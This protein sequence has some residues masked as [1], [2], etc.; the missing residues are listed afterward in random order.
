ME[1]I[2]RPW[3]VCVTADESGAFGFLRRQI[4]TSGVELYWDTFSSACRLRGLSSPDGLVF[5]VPLRLGPRSRYWQRPVGKD[6]LPAMHP[7]GLDWV[8]DRRQSHLMLVIRSSLLRR[9]FGE[10]DCATLEGSVRKHCVPAKAGEF[11]RLGEWLSG[12][13]NELGQRSEV[14]FR[15]EASDDLEEQ[16]LRRLEQ[17]IDFARAASLNPASSARR[18]GLEIALAYLSTAN[19]PTVTITQLVEIA[20]VSQR[21]LELAFRDIFDLTP[22]GFLRLLRLHAARRALMVA[23]AQGTTVASIADSHG[24]AQ[25]GRFSVSYRRL[26]G[27]SPSETLHRSGGTPVVVRWP[28]AER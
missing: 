1:E 26:F 23:E 24:F 5:L 18:R 10:E 8:V 12:L 25:H 3:R 13:I 19:L 14:L 4:R 16:L 20:G 2:W 15:P 27:E 17:T 21:T 9:R 28:D 7:G 22:S 6:Q 11:R